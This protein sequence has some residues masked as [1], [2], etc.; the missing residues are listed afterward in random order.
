MSGFLT[1]AWIHAASKLELTEI[2]ESLYAD[3]EPNYGMHS[4]S[5][6]AQITKVWAVSKDSSEP[7]KVQIS[8]KIHTINAFIS[9]EVMSQFE[10]ER[11]KYTGL[12]GTCIYVKKYSFGIHDNASNKS[13]LLS[14]GLHL[15]LEDLMF[16]GMSGID[17]IGDPRGIEKETDISERLHR[18][19]ELYDVTWK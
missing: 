8:D 5:L 9:S 10:E 1:R 2:L 4:K 3:T 13:N 12:F 7:F 6:R 19:G 18:I 15:Q 17:T 11:R 14:T 16:A